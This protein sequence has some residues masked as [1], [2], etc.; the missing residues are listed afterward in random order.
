MKTTSRINISWLILLFFFVVG[1]GPDSGQTTLDIKGI[2]SKTKTYVGSS[3]CKFCHLE[4]NHSWKNTLHS[5]TL[6]DV[7]KNQDALIVEF[8]PEV[9]RADLEKFEGKLKV[10]IDKIHI[11]KIEDVK[12]TM[13]M[14]WEQ[15]F[16]IE[17]NKILYVAPIIYNARDNKWYSHN[18]DKWDKEPWI[19]KCGGCHATGVDLK[20]NRFSEPRI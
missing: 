6:Q 18:E 2:L 19:E 4:H 14:Q 20:E 13:G 10:S 1:C 12:Y 9:I 17:K 7:T 5:R 15:A 3:E 11:P 8:D 16:L